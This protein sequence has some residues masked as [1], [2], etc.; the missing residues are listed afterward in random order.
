[1]LLQALF[2]ISAG[3]SHTALR[4]PC[5]SAACQQ[6]ELR[7][8]AS[9][10]KR[11]FVGRRLGGRAAQTARPFLAPARGTVCSATTSGPTFSPWAVKLI[12]KLSDEA[13]SRDGK[14]IWL[15][16]GAQRRRAQRRVLAVL[17]LLLSSFVFANR[18]AMEAPLNPTAAAVLPLANMA[19]TATTAFFNAAGG[20]CVPV[21]FL[22]W[23]VNSKLDGL[24]ESL[25]RDVKRQVDEANTELGADQTSHRRWTRRTLIRQ[26]GLLND[27]TVDLAANGDVPNTPYAQRASKC[28]RFHVARTHCAVHAR[29]I[30]LVNV[31]NGLLALDSKGTIEITSDPTAVSTEIELTYNYRGVMKTWT[32]TAPEGKLFHP[33]ML[34]YAKTVV[35]E[36]TR[37]IATLQFLLPFR[38]S[39]PASVAS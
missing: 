27:V 39:P 38:D 37:L 24:M 35:A 10:D 36:G 4:Q 17:G 3:F 32:V 33:H 7:S 9:A 26:R 19:S 28:T 11:H 34:C 23:A 14:R 21:A 13:H 5:A 12:G 30:I 20:Y 8:C 31:P 2:V 22:V 18:L 1:M 15:G 6:L 29:R 16:P 25:R